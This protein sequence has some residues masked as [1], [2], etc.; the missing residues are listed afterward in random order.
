MI[1]AITGIQKFSIVTSNNEEKTKGFF[2]L[3]RKRRKSANEYDVNIK[4]S[5]SGEEDFYKLLHYIAKGGF[6]LTYDNPKDAIVLAPEANY[7]ELMQLLQAVQLSEENELNEYILQIPDNVVVHE[8]L[9]FLTGWNFN[10]LEFRAPSASD[11]IK[12]AH[13]YLMF[14][15]QQLFPDKLVFSFNFL[16]I[17]GDVALSERLLIPF[18]VIEKDSET[19]LLEDKS[20]FCFADLPRSDDE[21]D[22]K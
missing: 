10:V 12:F 2:F 14:K 9:L 4:V 7:D 18:K 15:I 11:A 21:K 6:F 5:A 1:S 13:E 3:G 16:D 22:Q 8:Q 20:V 19:L 17:K